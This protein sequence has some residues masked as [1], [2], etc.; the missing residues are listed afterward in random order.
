MTTTPRVFI[1]FDFDHDDDLR[2][3]F[4]GQARNK[5]SPFDFSNYS[6]GE[7]LS[8]NWKKK[9][10]DRINL[11]SKTI[12]ICGH[13]THTAA[14]VSEE[15]KIVRELR[16]PYLLLNGRPDGRCTKPAAAYPT[17]QII[18]WTWNNIQRFLQAPR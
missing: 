3:L 13:T 7:A 11:T 5:N 18:P 17:D 1:S 6:L 16:K 8:G 4:V 10:Q 15:L 9:I 2:N 12:V 14:G